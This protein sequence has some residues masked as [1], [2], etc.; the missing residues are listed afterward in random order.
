MGH[1]I[2]TLITI[3]ICLIRKESPKI[4]LAAENPQWDWHL[5]LNVMLLVFSS[6][7]AIYGNY[8]PSEPS[9]HYVRMSSAPSVIRGDG[10]GGTHLSTAVHGSTL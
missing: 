5:A 7:D 4:Q 8:S 6:H 2:H 1:P 3:S 9:A 10:I